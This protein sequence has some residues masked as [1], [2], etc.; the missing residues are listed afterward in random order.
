MKLFVKSLQNAIFTQALDL[1][2]KS[3]FANQ[4]IHDTMGLFDGDQII[5]PVPNNA[6]AEIPRIILKNKNESYSLNVGLNRIDFFYNE[7]VL[8]DNLPTKELSKLEQ[9]FRKKTN[10]IVQT[11]LN[12]A[13]T[14]IV[15]LGFIVTLQSGVSGKASS[16]ISEKYLKQKKSTQD[17][18]DLNLGILKKEKIGHTVSNIWFRINPF[19]KEGDPLDDKMITVQFDVNT[20]VE[21]MLNFSLDDI[22]KYFEQASD[23]INTRLDSYIQG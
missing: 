23:Y 5:L 4:I 17:V 2:N 11:I 13:S 14:R 15:R 16:F 22:N 3:G 6:P 19:R 9:D 10:S 20:L 7:I 8:K 18:Y 12:I 21:E 1:T